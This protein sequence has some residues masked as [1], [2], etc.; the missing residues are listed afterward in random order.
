MTESNQTKTHIFTTKL[1]A[2]KHENKLIKQLNY[3]CPDMAKQISQTALLF[4][5]NLLI[6]LPLCMATVSAMSLI[7]NILYTPQPFRNR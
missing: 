3:K 4:D 2:K 5:I 6:N 7:P 1:V